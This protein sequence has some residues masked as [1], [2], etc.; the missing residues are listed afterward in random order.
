MEM[1]VSLACVR[2][3]GFEGGK[4]FFL[5]GGSAWRADAHEREKPVWEAGAG[6]A[7]SGVHSVP[8]APRSP[9]QLE[10]RERERGQRGRPTNHAHRETF[11]GEVP[12]KRRRGG[13]KGD[14]FPESL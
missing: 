3:R 10:A 11:C 5:G 14:L 4:F 9:Q 13:M 2:F 12:R 6:T 8:A 7:I 1:S